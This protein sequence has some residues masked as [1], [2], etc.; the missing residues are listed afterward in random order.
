MDVA[1]GKRLLDAWD[2]GVGRGMPGQVRAV[3]QEFAAHLDERQLGSMTLGERDRELLIIRRR[4]FGDHLSATVPCRSCGERLEV[5]VDAGD[6]LDGEAHDRGLVTVHA[7][8][9]ITIVARPPSV[10]DFEVAARAA[11]A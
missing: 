11:D 8:G 5:A 2:S 3:L 1:D 6:L 9:D 10:E 4:L 7:P